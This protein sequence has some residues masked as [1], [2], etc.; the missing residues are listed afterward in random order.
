METSDGLPPQPTT[1]VDAPIGE[2]VYA[3]LLLTESYFSEV[4]EVFIYNIFA[5]FSSTAQAKITAIAQDNAE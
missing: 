2:P 5:T 3:D 1:P 4:G